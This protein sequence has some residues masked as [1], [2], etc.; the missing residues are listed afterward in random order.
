MDFGVKEGLKNVK[1]YVVEHKDTAD[2][3]G[4]KGINV[5]S[6]PTLIL[7]I[8][9]TCL[10]AVKPLLPEGYETVGTV[11]NFLHLAATPVGQKVRVEAELTKVEKGKVLTFEVKCY[12]E[13]GK[14]L[15]GTHGRAIVNR[16]QFFGN[17]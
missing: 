11:F 13:K 2:A 8:E 12:D 1:E 7:W 17:L 16:E 14:I 10:E 4:N 15:K 3:V 6:S 5:L 9:M